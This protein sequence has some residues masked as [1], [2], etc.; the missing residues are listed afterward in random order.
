VAQEVEQDRS[1]TL[2]VLV[3]GE[4][5]LYFPM[6]AFSLHALQ[7]LAAVNIFGGMTH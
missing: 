4:A 7:L 2:T 1:I 3:H 5:I 6:L